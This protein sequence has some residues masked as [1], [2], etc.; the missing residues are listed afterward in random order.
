MTILQ[1]LLTE[2]EMTIKECSMASGVSYSTVSDLVHGKTRVSNASGAVLYKLSQ[3]LGV[4]MEYLIESES[5]NTTKESW[6]NFRSNT[7]HRIKDMG[8]RKFI[9]WMIDSKKPFTYWNRGQKAESLYLVATADY[10]CRLNALPKRKEFESL[11]KYKLT[12]PKFPQDA[13]IAEHFGVYKKEEL[14]KI[15]IPEYMSFNIVE[16]DI[17]N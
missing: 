16:E 13:A 5:D 7:Y 2:K 6:D 4:S 3:M 17:R 1:Q 15:A 12:K 10:L 14:V 11:R 9:R 8:D